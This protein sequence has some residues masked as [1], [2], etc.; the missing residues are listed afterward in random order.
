MTVRELVKQAQIRLR[1]HV[2]DLT[3]DEAAEWLMKLTAIQGNCA[4]EIR[5][6]DAE[7]SEVLLTFL[8]T[9][10]TANRARI[11]AETTSAYQRKRIARD[12]KELVG[13]MVGSLKYYL[14]TKEDEYRNARHHQ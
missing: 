2:A 8:D 10:K 5:V 12:T 1:D 7:Y 14:R 4:D 9:E 3:P 11:R 6:A 13:E